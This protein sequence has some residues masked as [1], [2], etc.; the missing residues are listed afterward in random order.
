MGPRQREVYR[1]SERRAPCRPDAQLSALVIDIPADSSELEPND[2]ASSRAFE[3]S[4]PGPQTARAPDSLRSSTPGAGGGGLA[5]RNPFPREPT[6]PP[7]PRATSALVSGKGPG[8]RVQSAAEQV[9][10]RAGPGPTQSSK[11][12]A[13]QIA[14]FRLRMDKLQKVVDDKG[15]EVVRVKA[16]ATKALEGVKTLD[17]SL[18]RLI[19]M[20]QDLEATVESLEA[21]VDSL[22]NELVEIGRNEPSDKGRGSLT[23]YHHHLIHSH[24][25]YASLPKD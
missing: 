9:L 12:I 1:K 8:G 16:A 24:G 21:R 17:E 14:N 25:S 19:G 18:A 6:A 3:I 7:A 11:G 4:S 13:D 23:S 20:T 5:F 2:L 15:A 22:E 10:A